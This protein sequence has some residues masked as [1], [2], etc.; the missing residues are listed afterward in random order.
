M[1]S[2]RL[3]FVFRAGA[4]PSMNVI[5]WWASSGGWPRVANPCT[6]AL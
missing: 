6:A 4:R 3:T 1:A 5:L 2:S